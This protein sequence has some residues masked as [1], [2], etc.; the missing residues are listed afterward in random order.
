MGLARALAALPPAPP[1]ARVLLGLEARDD[2]AALRSARGDVL[3]ATVDGFRA[4]CDDPWLVGRVAALNAVSD[5]YAK[6]G[7]PRHAL[8]WATLPEGGAEATLA[9]LLAGVR[10]E[11]D[12]L[13][14]SLV[15]GHS[16]LG[17]ELAVGLAVLGELPDGVPPIA[18]SGLRVGDALIL[19]KRLGTGVVLA[20]DMR[21]LA[22]ARW[23]EAAH[24]SMTSSNAPAAAVLRRLAS[25]A[26]DVSGFGLAGHLGE[27]L[28]A[29]GVGAELAAARLPAL[30][31]ARELLARGVR[32]TFAALAAEASPP[33]QGGDAPTHA[34]VCDPQTSGGVLFGVAAARADEALAALREA[35]EVH[36][37]RIGR[38]TA[39]AGGI[40][41]V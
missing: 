8:C 1:D 2:A 22:P 11:L 18:K 29:S 15:G 4:F 7:S 16:T 24:R 33:L 38:V 25:A 6:G 10:R 14:V 5:V 19:T 13:G 26:T 39:A 21:G 31:G 40:A 23:V 37:A 27:L 17:P 9:E 41:F 36:A 30:P 32:S 28:V 35:G 20:A 12:G 3:L 34:L